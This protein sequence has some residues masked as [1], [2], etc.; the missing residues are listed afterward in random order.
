M[1]ISIRFFRFLFGSTLNSPTQ[2]F[3]SV[4][5]KRQYSFGAIRELLFG[6]GPG[7]RY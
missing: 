7:T 3:G 1:S 4:G 2:W 5:G 6:S